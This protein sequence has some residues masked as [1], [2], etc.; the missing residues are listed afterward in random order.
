MNGPVPTMSFRGVFVAQAFMKPSGS[1]CGLKR[2][3][4][5]CGRI[6]TKVRACSIA[7]YGRGAL[8]FTV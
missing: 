6:G 4:L 3:S 5:C 2:A 7:P 8:T 1:R